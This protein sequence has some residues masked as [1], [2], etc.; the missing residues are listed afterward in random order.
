MVNTPTPSPS[1]RPATTMSWKLP[2]SLRR[3]AHRPSQNVAA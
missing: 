3:A 1:R 2:V